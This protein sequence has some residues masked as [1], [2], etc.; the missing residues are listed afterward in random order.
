MPLKTAPSINVVAAGE[1]IAAMQRRYTQLG[2]MLYIGNPK[3]E[4]RHTL[5]AERVWLRQWL[6]QY[7]VLAGIAE[8]PSDV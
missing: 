3:K 8:E 7:E 6:S 5:L 2:D 4:Q 1:T